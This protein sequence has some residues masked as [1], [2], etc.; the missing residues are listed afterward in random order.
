MTG[1]LI[2]NVITTTVHVADD[3]TCLV[4]GELL[5]VACYQ[6]RCE[7]FRKQRFSK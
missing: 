1:G 7:S 6:L 3:Y 5:L 4:D 2:R